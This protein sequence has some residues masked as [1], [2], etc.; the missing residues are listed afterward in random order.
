MSLIPGSVKYVT[1][2]CVQADIRIPA[3]AKTRGNAIRRQKTNSPDVPGQAIG[4]FPNHLDGRVAILLIDPH[5]KQGGHALFLQ[6]HH[7]LAD[8]AVFFPSSPDTLEFAAGNTWYFEE[9]FHVSLK[10]IQGLV[11]KM[12]HD[13]AGSLWAYAA[14]KPRTKVFFQGGC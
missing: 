8:G 14:N 7:H 5:S 4:I 6:K 13:F 12:A 9:T 1:Y 11:A 3:Q 10:D 2:P